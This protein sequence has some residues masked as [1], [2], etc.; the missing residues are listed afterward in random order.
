MRACVRVRVCVQTLLFRLFACLEAPKF[1]RVHADA[2][3]H[4]GW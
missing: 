3:V 4:S 2:F 1:T